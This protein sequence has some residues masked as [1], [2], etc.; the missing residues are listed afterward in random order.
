MLILSFGLVMLSKKVTLRSTRLRTALIDADVLRYEVGSVGQKLNKETGEIEYQ[1]FDFVKEVFDER[2]R[3]IVEGSASK[4]YRLFL[5]GDRNTFRM[6]QR[7][8]LFGR[9]VSTE[10]SRG[11]CSRKS[12]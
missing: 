6:A 2:I 11:S 8:N 1:S 7:S 12:I 10:L 3:T 9:R 5:T 4:D